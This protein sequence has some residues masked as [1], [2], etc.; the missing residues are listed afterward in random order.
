MNIHVE[1]NGLPGSYRWHNVWLKCSH[2]EK[3]LIAESKFFFFSF[4]LFFFCLVS[5]PRSR[6]VAAWGD[7]FAC[8][9]VIVV[10]SVG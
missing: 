5:P 2:D 7:Y 8:K 6:I 9:Q 3:C 4:S 10:R 1:K